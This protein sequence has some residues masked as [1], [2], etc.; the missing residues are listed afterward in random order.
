MS[1]RNPRAR[2]EEARPS[3]GGNFHGYLG[4]NLSDGYR[5]AVMTLDDQIAA[6]MVNPEMASLDM[7]A[8]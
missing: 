6:A 1:E 5:M 3:S 2:A 8:S 7:L 4:R